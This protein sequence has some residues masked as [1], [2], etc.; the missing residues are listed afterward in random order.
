METSRAEAILFSRS[1]NELNKEIQAIVAKDQRSLH[2]RAKVFAA[3]VKMQGFD[4]L[5]ETGTPEELDQAQKSGGIEIQRGL[6]ATRGVSSLFYARELI[7]GAMYPGTQ[8]ALGHG[9]YFATPS[10]TDGNK[11]FPRMSKIAKIY[12]NGQDGVGFL[13]RAVLKKGCNC[14]NCDD[15]KKELRENRNRAVK[16]GITDIGAYAAS[17]GVDAFKAD[18][19]AEF[20]DNLTLLLQQGTAN[21]ET[22]DVAL[23]WVNAPKVRQAATKNGYQLLMKQTLVNMGEKSTTFG[24]FFFQRKTK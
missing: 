23:E 22:G 16:A 3:I 24:L 6:S 10:I 18:G 8:I 12:T 11:G 2:P 21:I 15:L 14:A 19:M 9:M 7:L 1:S 13:V 17:L 4:N 20:V 5:P